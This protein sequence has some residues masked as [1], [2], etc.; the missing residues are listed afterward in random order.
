MNSK[1]SLM[2]FAK[3]LKSAL[4]ENSKA[5]SMDSNIILTQC[6]INLN[7]KAGM[8]YD[9]YSLN[10][11][12]EDD[13]Q[14]RAA[15]VL[16]DVVY[17]IEAHFKITDN[18][19]NNPPKHK[20]MFERRAKKGQCFHMPYFGCREFPVNFELFEGE[21]PRSP[22]QGKVVDLGWMLHDIDFKNNMEAK[23]FRAQMIDG[24]I[25]VP[26]LNEGGVR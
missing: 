20:E 19:D 7:K 24:V 11:F 21:I 26:P 12:V 17:I 10:I 16:R 5:L 1:E 15:M 9:N 6:L 2:Q 13:R 23:F 25:D 18:E 3:N 4:Y 14:Q 22:L 8:E